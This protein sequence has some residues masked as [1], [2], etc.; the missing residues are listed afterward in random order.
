MLSGN[1]GVTSGPTQ[2]G[3][4]WGVGGAQRRPLVSNTFGAY[5][6]RMAGTRA[7]CTSAGLA[8]WQVVH[9]RTIQVSRPQT[10][11]HNS[12]VQ[13]A[14]QGC[15]VLYLGYMQ[16]SEPQDVEQGALTMMAC[17]I[18]S[19]CLNISDQTRQAGEE[20][21]CALIAAGTV[22]SN[23]GNV[24]WEGTCIFTSYPQQGKAWCTFIAHAATKVQQGAREECAV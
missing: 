21:D 7:G 12:W 15:S 6:T 14:A 23:C 5:A 2:H 20:H 8:C 10:G 18:S 19:T 24:S 4:L 17:Q 16:H 1:M 11:D 9:A 3:R 13:L 22:R